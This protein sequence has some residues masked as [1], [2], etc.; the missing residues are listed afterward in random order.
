[1]IDALVRAMARRCGLLDPDAFARMREAE[2][3]PLQ[4][5]ERGTGR[6]TCMLLAALVAL[7]VGCTVEIVAADE[8]HAADLQERWRRL[9]DVALP[10]RPY[11]FGRWPW[12]EIAFV[13][14]GTVRKGFAPDVRLVDHYADERGAA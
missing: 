1:M 13:P 5:G 11:A 10:K 6:T 3:R 9:A 8:H 2:G 7:E 12:P 14:V 4:R